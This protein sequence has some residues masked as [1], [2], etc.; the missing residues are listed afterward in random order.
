MPSLGAGRVS[1]PV[2]TTW[3]RT[4][5]VPTCF[6]ILPSLFTCH[7]RHYHLPI[8]LP[9]YRHSQCTLGEEK[10]R[11]TTT[12][13]FYHAGDQAQHTTAS[14]LLPI[15]MA[16]QLEDSTHAGVSCNSL[17]EQLIAQTQPAYPPSAHYCLYCFVLKAFSLC[18]HCNL[19]SSA[20]T[21]QPVNQTLGR[22]SHH[23]SLRTSG[24]RK[25]RWRWRFGR[26]G[27]AQCCH[28]RACCRPDALP[29]NVTHARADGALLLRG[30]TFAPRL[31]AADC[32]SNVALF[33]ACAVWC[34]GVF[35]AP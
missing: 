3:T 28:E 2:F 10:E 23:T 25:T 32:L 35:R 5:L 21:S 20:A 15:L 9:S 14:F 31:Q 1:R 27:N 22:Q 17:L 29:P 6:C 13:W 18:T 33:V 30:C 24:R 26:L 16:G 4:I 8:P 34:A 12:P 7:T 11:R 19:A